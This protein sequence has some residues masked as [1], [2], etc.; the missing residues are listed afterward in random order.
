MSWFSFLEGGLENEIEICKS[1]NLNHFF[2]HWK[3]V[4]LLQF[5]RKILFICLD[6]KSARIGGVNHNRLS[7]TR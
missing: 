5:L 3:E 2:N 6:F 7:I 4:I 1:Y